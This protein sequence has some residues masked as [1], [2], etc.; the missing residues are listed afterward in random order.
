M[1]PSFMKNYKKLNL[2]LQP[3]R[4][5]LW[6]ADNER[7]KIILITADIHFVK[8]KDQLIEKLQFGVS[9]VFVFPVWSSLPFRKTIAK[10]IPKALPQLKHGW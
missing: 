3:G 6:M 10:A 8:I 1:L 7:K 2:D 5:E 4:C 9:F